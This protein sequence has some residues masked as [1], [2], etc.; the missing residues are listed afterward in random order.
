MAWRW[1]TALR[2]E[3]A[4]EHQDGPE[5]VLG[6]DLR[7]PEAVQA[8]IDVHAGAD[9]E[10]AD[11][12]HERHDRTHLRVAVPARP[13]AHHRRMYT[14]RQTHAFHAHI[15]RTNTHADA[16]CTMAP[17]CHIPHSARTL[18]CIAV[19]ITLQYEYDQRVQLVATRLDYAH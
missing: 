10:D 5:E 2:D 18:L 1:R 15:T 14:T 13:K 11:A 6:L 8:V 19:A 12:A 9:E 17:T 7:E 16:H 3:R 4:A